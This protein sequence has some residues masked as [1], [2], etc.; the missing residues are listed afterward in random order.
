MCQEAVVSETD[1]VEESAHVG[2]LSEKKAREAG[3][4]LLGP[5]QRPKCWTGGSRGSA[6]GCVCEVEERW[7]GKPVLSRQSGSTEFFFLL[8]LLLVCFAFFSPPPLLPPVWSLR[9][10]RPRWGWWRPSTVPM[11]VGSGV[12]TNQESAVRPAALAGQAGQDHGLEPQPRSAI[13]ELSL[14]ALPYRRIGILDSLRDRTCTTATV[15]FQPQ[16][17][18]ES[19]NIKALCEGN[20]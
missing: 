7:M 12:P 5:D 15:G 1:E 6:E 19:Q 2:G 17:A 11:S 9:Q 4:T 3:H 18:N 20:C 8:L 16:D 10:T 14:A 13:C